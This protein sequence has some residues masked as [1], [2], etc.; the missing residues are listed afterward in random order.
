MFNYDLAIRDFWRVIKK[1]KAII[2]LVT[3]L[4]GLISFSLAWIN[5]PEPM[6]EATSEVKYEQP[7]LIMSI[8]TEKTFSLPWDVIATQALLIKSFP[9]ME[10]V[11]KE[12]GIIDRAV[13]IDQVM[14]TKNF[15]DL[16]NSIQKNISTERKD[17]TNI[18]SITCR[19]HDPRMAQRMAN[20]V[21]QI[22]RENNSAEVNRRLLESINFIKEQSNFVEEKLKAAEERRRAIQAVLKAPL[23]SSHDKLK[24]GKT[25]SDTQT[26]NAILTKN[27]L[28]LAELVREIRVNEELLF[29]LQSKY[30]EALIKLSERAEEVSIIHPA[31]EPIESINFTRVDVTTITGTIF[32]LLLGLLCA[33]LKERNNV[34]I[35]IIESVETYSEVPVIGTIPEVDIKKLKEHYAQIKDLPDDDQSLRKYIAM[36][37]HFAPKSSVSE[38]YRLLRTNLQ[39]IGL[40]KK[41]KSFIITSSTFREGKT[42]TL[43]NLGLTMA[44]TGK[45]TLIVE[46]DLRKPSIYDVFGLNK[47]PGLTDIILGNYTWK[48]VVKTITDIMVGKLE[49]PDILK[50]PGLE[51]LS[52]ITCGC[53]PPNPFEILSSSKMSEFIA[54]VERHYDVV[55]FDTPPVLL[56]ADALI[57]SQQVDG[58]LLVYEVDKVSRRILKRAKKQ[59]DNVR[60][61]IWGIILNHVKPAIT[62][63]YYKYRMNHFYGIEEK[64]SVKEMS[65]FFASLFSRWQSMLLIIFC[66]LL[67]FA[68]ILWQKNYLPGYGSKKLFLP[69][70]KTDVLKGVEMIHRA[71]KEALKSPQ[72][73]THITYHPYSILI[74]SSKEEKNALEDWRAI[75]NQGYTAYIS[76]ADIKGKGEFF[77][78]FAGMLERKEE[79][80]EALKTI[81]GP[82]KPSIILTPYSLQIG[83]F[84]SRNTADQAIAKWGIKVYFPYFLPTDGDQKL[85]LLLG[86]FTTHEEFLT[87]S[88]KLG[89]KG[90]TY[91]VVQR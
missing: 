46:S 22:Y 36:I 1:R 74:S 32:G 18:I 84:P 44:H 27:A 53:I 21:A 85:R 11:A 24:N 2:I 60:G 38:A 48:E 91:Q 45:R 57:L 75:T 34:L 17:N 65:G 69:S 42:T 12:L 73:I 78:V 49:M 13:T 68:G 14:R 8:F 61:S 64:R 50:T 41:G 5:K 59:I 40:E 88:Q 10:K 71:Q 3:L 7:T 20:T 55:L 6:Y 56:F 29:F 81:K 51:N 54:E 90:I 63:D 4:V 39:F 83:I 30:R 16:I 67:I 86:A 25:V 33:F 47:E 89:E 79:A 66:I 82:F 19:T 77:R 62:T 87:L 35:R 80:R 15:L 72:E 9:V 23:P 70:I 58:A 37:C 26:K 31:Y 43:I 28:E 76:L 52:I